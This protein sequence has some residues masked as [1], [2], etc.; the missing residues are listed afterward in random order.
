MCLRENRSKAESLFNT[1][2]SEISL[3]RSYVEIV[4]GISVASVNSMNEV[5]N[6]IIN[7]FRWYREK[8]ARPI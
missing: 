2:L 6:K 8:R 4:V 1:S 7:K 3:F 5:N